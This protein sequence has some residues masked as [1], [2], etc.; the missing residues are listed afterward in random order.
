MIRT[1]EPIINGTLEALLMAQ[2]DTLEANVVE[3][4]RPLPFPARA[5]RCVRR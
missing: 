1:C 3:M 4:V 2:Y 5:A